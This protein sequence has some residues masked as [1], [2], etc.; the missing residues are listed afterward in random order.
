TRFRYD[1]VLEVGGDI[2]PPVDVPWHDWHDD[3]LDAGSL[4]AL[5]AAE[6]DGFGVS[7]IPNARVTPWLQRWSELSGGLPSGAA[8]GLST[9]D[10]RAMTAGTAY[11]LHL[12]CLSGQPDTAIDAAWLRAT[13]SPARP[14]FPLP[15]STAG[16]H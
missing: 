15:V 8:A 12:S 11:D 3:G 10:L 2:D 16:P 1:A 6:G 13:V 5:L 7:R 4:Q 9:E 14:R